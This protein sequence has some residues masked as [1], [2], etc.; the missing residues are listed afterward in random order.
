MFL[1][2]SAN[3]YLGLFVDFCK[4]LHKPLESRQ[5]ES[6]VQPRSAHAQIYASIKNASLFHV[7]YTNLITLAIYVIFCLLNK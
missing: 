6:E 1:C 2:L 3:R 7:L 4:F 5:H